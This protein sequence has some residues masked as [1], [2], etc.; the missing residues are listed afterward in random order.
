VY[1]EDISNRIKNFRIIKKISQEKMAELLDIT[2]SNYVKI[3][4][5]Y[6]NVTIKHLMGI[7][8]I[9][10]VSADILLFGEIDETNGLNFDDFIAYANIFSREELEQSVEKM[11]RLLK[12]KDVSAN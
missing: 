3:E 4:N 10:G 6:Q 12:L 2:Y 7:S 8:K 5:A 11:Q 1:T 9:L